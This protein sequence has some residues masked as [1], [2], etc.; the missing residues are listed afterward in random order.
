VE[1]ARAA[2][3]AAASADIRVISHQGSVDDVDETGSAA[4][5]AAQ[6]HADHNA[7]GR[8]GKTKPAGEAASSTKLVRLDDITSLL[9]QQKELAARIAANRRGEAME[10]DGRQRKAHRSRQARSKSAEYTSDEFS[11]GSRGRRREHSPER[12]C[13][14]RNAKNAENKAERHSKNRSARKKLPFKGEVSPADVSHEGQRDR[15]H[16]HSTE[17]GYGGSSGRNARNAPEHRAETDDS[18]DYQPRRSSSGASRTKS[19][20]RPRSGDGA[21][22]REK[23]GTMRRASR[24][25]RRDEELRPR[26]RRDQREQRPASGRASRRGSDDANPS[27]PEHRRGRDRGHQER[28]GGE[29]RVLKHAR[30]SSESDVSSRA[31]ESDVSQLSGE[32]SSPDEGG[33]PAPDASSLNAHDMLAHWRREAKSFDAPTM[34]ECKRILRLLKAF[35]RTPC[36]CAITHARMLTAFRNKLVLL[37]VTRTHGAAVATAYHIQNKT[38]VSAGAVD[39]RALEKAVKR[40]KSLVL[41]KNAHAG[42]PA[43]SSLRARQ[44]PSERVPK[45]RGT[46]SRNRGPRA[47]PAPAG[48]DR[49]KKNAGTTASPRSCFKCK[50]PGHVIADCPN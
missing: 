35:S 29:V 6:A 11:E 49:N 19:G 45:K 41:A 3:E 2:S 30:A 21:R 38:R 23:V 31:L 37:M 24:D 36:D 5:L 17:R 22:R 27:D 50:Q 48:V 47:D 18:G 8:G 42:E 25:D 44:R 20:D 1:L 12:E 40:N 33:K 28:G 39:L 15:R 7:H 26:D 10:D 16:G 13:H 14:D 46:D 32:S 43:A 4:D 34:R 9:E